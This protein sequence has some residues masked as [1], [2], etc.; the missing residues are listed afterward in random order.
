M[1]NASSILF[2]FIAIPYIVIKLISERNTV[3]KTK[4]STLDE[5]VKQKFNDFKNSIK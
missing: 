2:L 3:S 5:Q 1:V 4:N